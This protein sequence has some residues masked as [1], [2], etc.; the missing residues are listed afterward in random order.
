MKLMYL[1]RDVL[2]NNLIYNNISN[3][4]LLLTRSARNNFSI[5]HL[6]EEKLLSVHK[7]TALLLVILKNDLVLSLII[8]VLL[9][10]N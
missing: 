8:K 5:Y 3:F 4:P 10:L 6:K 9:W 2:I 1:I 7:S